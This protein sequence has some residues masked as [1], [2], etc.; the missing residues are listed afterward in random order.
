[1]S[2][3]PVAPNSLGS[4]ETDL[5]NRRTYERADVAFEY[6]H[7]EGLQPPE[8][9]IIDRIAAEVRGKAVLDLGVG[10]GRTTEAL[11]A[12]AGRYVALDYSQPMVE[13]CRHRYP[14]IDVRQGD[15]RDLSAFTAGSFSL[16]VFSFNGID[17]VGHA[18]RLKVLAEARRVLAPGGFFVFSS[19]NRESPDVGRGYCMP[20]FSPTLH[21]IKLIA[22]L[23]GFPRKALRS[24]RNYLRHRGAEVRTAEYAILNDS[25]HEH[26]LLTYHID[27]RQQEAQLAA[28]GFGLEGIY[29]QAGREAPERSASS[30]LYYLARARYPGH[31]SPRM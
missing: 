29:D 23:L 10:G 18:D 21:P 14:Q 12:L 3:Y 15:A 4:I 11:V 26:M 24:I 20:R 13:A 28:A 2:A 5:L 16:V 30:W 7:S 1:M 19:H 22:Q 6:A 25:A 27:R 31:R 8:R 9:V 17:Y